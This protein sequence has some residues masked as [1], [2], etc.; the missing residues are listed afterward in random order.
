[1][2]LQ[3]K[4]KATH[5]TPKLI[6]IYPGGFRYRATLVGSEVGKNVGEIVKKLDT[7]DKTTKA[8]GV[9]VMSRLIGETIS[10]EILAHVILNSFDKDSFDGE[11]H[12]KD[13]IPGDIVNRGDDRDWFSRTGIQIIDLTNLPKSGS[14]IDKG[15]AAINSLTPVNQNRIDIYLPVPPAFKYV[16]YI[17]V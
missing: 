12:N 9:E 10:H 15:I 7:V 8:F 1:M 5:Q 17:R 4:L 2:A 16:F 13:S 3:E 14:F 11:G 6:Y